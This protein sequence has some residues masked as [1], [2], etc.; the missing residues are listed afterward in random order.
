MDIA[1]D[2]I[3]EAV[4]ERLLQRSNVGYKKYNTTLQENNKDNFINHALE[5][6]LDFCNYLMKLQQQ[7]LDITQLVKQYPNDQELGVKIRSIYGN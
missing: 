5:E 6:S 1:Q 4:R 7:Q 2:S 3:V